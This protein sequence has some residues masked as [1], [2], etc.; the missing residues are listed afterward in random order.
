MVA[1]VLADLGPDGQQ[2]TLALV[3]AGAVLVRLAEVA[4]HDR[5][6]DGA[7]DLAEGDLR[8]WAG[9]HV[10]AADAPFGS[11]EAGAFQGEE[12]LLEVW[13]GEARA[14]G[15]VADR[16]RRRFPRPQRQRQQRTAGVVAPRRYLHVSML[17]RLP[18]PP[19]TS[20]RCGLARR[21]DGPG[22]RHPERS[23]GRD[24]GSG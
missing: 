18:T 15:D 20:L 4:G 9:Q 5:S 14:L 3:V 10:A 6:V 7:D 21:G 13:L 23:L 12:N 16:R 22:F 17:R 19:P 11:D 1:H 2:D 24:V 8:R